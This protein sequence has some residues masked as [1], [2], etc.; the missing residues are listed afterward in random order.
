[1]LSRVYET[2][3]ATGALYRLSWQ[4]HGVDG[5]CTSLV[6]ILRWIEATPTPFEL[7]V[8]DPDRGRGHYAGEP[9]QI[10]GVRYIHRPLRVWIDLAERLGLRL[11][12][13]RLIEAP[14][15]RLRFEPLD[16]GARIAGGEPGT[17]KCGT[18]SDFARIHKTEDPSFVIDMREALARVAPRPNARVLYVGCNTGDEIQLVLDLRPELDPRKGAA[19]HLGIDHSASALA[20]ARERFTDYPSAFEE[21]WVAQ[22]APHMV[23]PLPEPTPYVILL[24]LDVT[25]AGALTKITRFDLIVSI[26]TLQSPGIDDRDLLRELVQDHLE[27]TGSI[28]LG[29]P[30]CRYVDGETEYGARMKNFS[31]PELGLVIKDIAFYR[32]YLQQHW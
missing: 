28:I 9:V 3:S 15:I 21:M 7:D 22:R 10:D 18:E 8:L 11:C 25:A 32:R 12:T 1:M 16:R 4:F 23:E 2:S 31:Q 20:V 6:E 26:G 19:K 13:P 5:A 24:D 30:N 27:P 14:R 17:E 29:V